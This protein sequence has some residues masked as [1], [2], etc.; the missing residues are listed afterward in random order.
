M[1]CEYC[2]KNDATIDLKSY[3]LAFSEN[4]VGKGYNTCESCFSSLTKEGVLKSHYGFTGMLLK[5]VG[6]D[7]MRY[8][9]GY[10]HIKCK[11]C[12][13]EYK[14]LSNDGHILPEDASEEDKRKWEFYFQCTKCNY[15]NLRFE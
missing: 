3:F 12:G 14:V 2:N 5:V 7:N 1:I 13:S 10:V 4:N 9:N 6:K 11:D 15:K 8:E